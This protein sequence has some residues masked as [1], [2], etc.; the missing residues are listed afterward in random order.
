MNYIINQTNLSNL[1]SS[2]ELLAQSMITSVKFSDNSQHNAG[3][4]KAAIFLEIDQ[5][6]L[7]KNGPAIVQQLTIFIECLLAQEVPITKIIVEDTWLKN[8]LIIQA[9]AFLKKKFPTG[10]GIF[11]ISGQALDLDSPLPQKTLIAK[12][13]NTP[14]PQIDMTVLN[15]HI[16]S[17]I[18]QPF[19]LNQGQMDCCGVA[20]YLM[21]ILETQPELYSE[22]TYDLV[23]AGKSERIVPLVAPEAEILTKK[24]QFRSS[25]SAIILNAFQK[26]QSF[27]EKIGVPIEVL[28][29]FNNIIK[30]II[31]KVVT[32]I[33]K[34][35]QSYISDDF[36]GKIAN[37]PRQIVHYLRNSGYEVIKET[38]KMLPIEFFKEIL[39]SS[40]ISASSLR[41]QEDIQRLTYS[42]LHTTT[43][44]LLNEL[45]EIQTKLQNNHQ[46][47]LLLES[48]WNWKITGLEGEL[49]SGLSHYNYCKDFQ[50]YTGKKEDQD[51]VKFTIYT[52]GQ[53]F[54]VKANLTDFAKHY[55][56]VILSK[57]K[58]TSKPKIIL[59]KSEKIKREPIR[60]S[61]RLIDLSNQPENKRPRYDSTKEENPRPQK[62][63]KK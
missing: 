48:Q 60:K 44:N 18:K 25:S 41:I 30:S 46:A 55:C 42:D 54:K 17:R 51:K 5:P 57:L 20:T 13:D 36:S 58:N 21:Q 23:K 24:G 10:L 26:P 19:T 7:V 59:P 43:Q 2:P 37:L 29:F 39:P 15:K 11:G 61:D 47:I 9:N 1:L 4:H 27:L 14:Y 38:A 12:Q 35:F 49:P 45:K 31:P 52:W 40:N 3:S 16:R 32:D 53:E 63:Y 28:N 34:F 22:L 56:G 50:L 8:P 6:T 62:K 33:F